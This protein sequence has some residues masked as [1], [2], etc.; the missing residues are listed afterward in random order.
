[1][2]VETNAACALRWAATGIACFP[3]LGCIVEESRCGE[4]QVELS[5]GYT[6]CGCAP[7]FVKRGLSCEACPPDQHEVNGACECMAG[8]AM[9]ADGACVESALGRACSAEQPCAGD[10]PFC[11]TVDG[12]SYCTT[13]GCPVSG[14]PTDYKC[15]TEDSASFCRKVSGLGKPCTSPMDCAGTE[16][17]YCEIVFVNRC[18]VNGCLGD[19]LKCPSGYSC[20]DYTS[21]LSTSL[22]VRD[23]FLMDGLCVGGMPPVGR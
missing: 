4:N 20:C 9:A 21:S 10:Y 19:P 22:C 3:M 11:A 6:A 17:T 5:G 8:F 2:R 7:G 16:A 23:D 14:C 13:Q 1:M 15:T 18:I 12:E